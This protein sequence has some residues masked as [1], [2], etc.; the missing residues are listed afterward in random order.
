MGRRRRRKPL[1]TEPVEAEIESLTQDGK[2]VTHIEGKATFVYGSLPGERVRF[3]YTGRQRKY[4]EGR[5]VE[6]MQ[7]SSQRVEPRCSQFGI[8]GGCGLQHQKPEAQVASKQQAMLDAL[9]HIGK[10]APDEILAPLLGESVWGYRRKARLG[11]RYVPKKGGT[12]V[13]FRERGS[14]FVADIDECHILHPRVGELLPQLSALIDQL[15]IRDQ[16]PQIEMAMGDEECILI[17]RMLSAPSDDDLMKLAIFGPQYRIAVYLQEG[18][19]ETIR[20]LDFEPT[21][22]SYDLP[23][24]DL[25]LDFLPNDFTQVNTDINRQ[26]IKRA[27]ALL[28]L[29]AEDRVLDLFCGL[30]NFTLPL[31][32]SAGHV[33]GVEGDSGLVTRA[34]ENA[35]RNGIDNVTFFTANLYGELDNEPW[36]MQQFNKVLLDPPRSGAVEILEHLPKLGAERIVYVSCYPGTLAR[37]A[38][39]LVH[40]LGYR[41]MS[42]GVMDMFPHTAH[43]ESIALFEKG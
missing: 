30:G 15:S 17:F 39:I 27:I 8:C 16:I 4:D 31:A 43:V 25:Q 18:G 5:V 3:L 10:V 33:T 24:F 42:A 41:L 6:V 20:P 2:G 12:L 35:L 14:S 36:L 22:L 32:L 13:G 38:G 11:V 19:P 37:D 23:D 28:G 21:T 26:M 7:P 9:K 1:P 40:D 29:Q 34:R